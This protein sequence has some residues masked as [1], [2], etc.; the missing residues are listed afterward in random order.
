MGLLSVDNILSLQVS[1][2]VLRVGKVQFVAT[3]FRFVFPEA[4][5]SGLI[6]NAILSLD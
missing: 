3:Q 2:R 6:D 4:P 1:E 5:V